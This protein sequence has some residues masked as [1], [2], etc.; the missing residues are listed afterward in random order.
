MSWL[1]AV[2][3]RLHAL[4]RRD[5]LAREMDEEMR[6]HLEL[7]TRDQRAA[8]A[9]TPPPSERPPAGD[10]GRSSAES[11]ARRRFGNMTTIRQDRR[12]ESGLAVVD[13]LLQDAGYA[14]RQITR[15]PGF[16][17]AVALTLALG[18]G[19]NATMF[20]IVD[21]VMLRAPEGI[22]D[23]GRVLQLRSWTTLRDGRRDSSGAMSYPSYMEF[24]ALTDVFERVTAV[25]GPMDVAVGRG[26]EAAN[27]RGALVSNDYFETLGATP[28]LGR[29][30]S[31][32]E[33]SETAG[34]PVVVLSH[35]YWMRRFGGA[36]DVIGRSLLANSTL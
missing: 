18:I 14:A 4:L 17:V 34:A 25:R 19:A 21:R 15:A 9:R 20:A 26:P 32:D 13:R 23:A 30:F 16:A 6:F 29:F 11:V 35:A 36:A 10:T 3:H 1:D 5:E 27:A 31:R 28:L 2:K 12:R 24:R 22:A 7:E 8:A 33:T